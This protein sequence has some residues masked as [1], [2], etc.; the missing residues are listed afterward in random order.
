MPAGKPANTRCCQL[1]VDNLCQL[2]G[3]PE[4]PAVCS[5]LQSHPDMCGDS[6]GHALLWLSQLEIDTRPA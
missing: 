2:F 5:G 1:S 3:R 6:Q 4:R